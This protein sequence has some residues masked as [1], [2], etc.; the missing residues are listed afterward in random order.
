V[1]ARDL[2]RKALEIYWPLVQKW[3]AAFA[4][5][6]RIALRNY[7]QV[8]PEDAADPWWGIW[9]QLSSEAEAPGGPEPGGGESA[10]DG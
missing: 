9:K 4:G 6:F 1:A 2:F 3:P 7:T 8:T 10:G 5:N